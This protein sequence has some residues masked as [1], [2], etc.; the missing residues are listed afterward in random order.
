MPLSPNGFSQYGV[1]GVVNIFEAQIKTAISKSRYTQNVIDRLAERDLYA[2]Q[3]LKDDV[4]ED[5]ANKIR[6]RTDADKIRA[7]VYEKNFAYYMGEHEEHLRPEWMKTG[8]S[9]YKKYNLLRFATKTYVDL[10][11]GGGVEILTGISEID[12]Y[13]RDEAGLPDY[14]S[15]WATAVSVMG[16]LGLQ[17][18]TDDDGVD[19]VVIHPK[20][21]Y[22]KW[23]SGSND[24][25]EWVAKK[26]NIDPSQLRLPEGYTLEDLGFNKPDEGDQ[27]DGIIFEERHYRGRIEYYLYTVKDDFILLVLDPR[28]LDDNLPPVDEEGISHQETGIDDFLLQIIPNQIFMKQF[29]TDYDDLTELQLSIN[30]R[31]TQRSRI[32]NIH[33]DPKLLVPED[34]QQKDPFTGEVLVRAFRD[35]VLFISPENADFKP[36]YLTWDAQLQEATDEFKNDVNMF[37]T[38]AEISGSLIIN[39]EQ[40]VPESGVAYKM[41]LTPTLNRVRRKEKDFKTALR[42]LL[43]VYVMQLHASG[44]LRYSDSEV[45]DDPTKD[46][47]E[48]LTSQ[49][50][51]GDVLPGSLNLDAF[52]AKNIEIKFKPT[53]P[54]DER[55]LLERLQGQQSISVERVLRD[56]D[57]LSDHEISVEMDRIKEDMTGADEAFGMAIKQEE[58][59]GMEANSPLDTAGGTGLTPGQETLTDTFNSNNIM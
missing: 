58:N 25:F 4:N 6:W 23:K 11:M 5:E 29:I 20:E 21:L 33:A 56:V 31:G 12:D 30:V 26:I 52:K 43:W 13:I 22:Y 59:F 44:E 35:E 3:F 34:M 8:K 2:R 49:R 51:V 7:S 38:L 54:Q 32:L 46:E 45:L 15:D 24:R 42:R 16:L 50:E 1:P 41:R 37:C 14:F 40:V 36:E 9:F 57:G 48:V 47:D 53:L 55:M 39:H 10:M 28:W 27:P 17:V 19:I 18:V